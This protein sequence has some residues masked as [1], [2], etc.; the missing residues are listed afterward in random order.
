MQH[1]APMRLHG[2]DER[3]ARS[4]ASKFVWVHA[5]LEHAGMGRRL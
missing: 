5:T 1:R 3:V 2:S 4:P